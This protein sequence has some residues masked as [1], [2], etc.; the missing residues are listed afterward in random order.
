[1]AG[2]TCLNDLKDGSPKIT[3]GEGKISHMCDASPAAFVARSMVINTPP[4]GQSTR[5]WSVG[6]SGAQNAFKRVPMLA[7]KV[8]DFFEFHFRNI[9]R[10]KLRRCRSVVVDLKHQP[11]GYFLVRVERSLQHLNPNSIGMSSLSS[12]T[13]V[14]DLRSLNEA[15]EMRRRV[16]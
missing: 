15:Q 16:G 3:I 13:S 8:D 5:A 7:S 12:R 11:G 4:L 2:T 10:E 14:N 1:M 6:M 9:V